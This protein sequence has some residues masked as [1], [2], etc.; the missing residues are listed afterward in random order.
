MCELND[1][2]PFLYDIVF[3]IN[4]NLDDAEERRLTKSF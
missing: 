1:K 2:T 4:I 3:V